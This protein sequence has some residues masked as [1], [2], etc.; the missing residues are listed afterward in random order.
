MLFAKFLTKKPVVLSLPFQYGC[1]GTVNRFSPQSWGCDGNR[2]HILLQLFSCMLLYFGVLLQ[3]FLIT[4]IVGPFPPR[5]SELPLRL[6]LWVKRGDASAEG[7]LMAVPAPSHPRACFSVFTHHSLE[8]ACFFVVR[9]HH[10]V[11]SSMR[12][13]PVCL[14]SHPPY[15]PSVRAQ[16]PAVREGMNG[17][18]D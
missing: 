6:A 14:V 7:V 8:P 17:W 3:L 13:G 4:L 11:M 5:D 2:D 9:L 12:A 15:R 1:H 16:G 10:V 18:S